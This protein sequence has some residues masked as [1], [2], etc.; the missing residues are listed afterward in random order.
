MC[1]GLFGALSREG[2]NRVWVEVRWKIKETR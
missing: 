1:V 2:L